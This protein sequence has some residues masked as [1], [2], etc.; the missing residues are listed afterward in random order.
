V[1]HISCYD[2]A[3]N[4]EKTISDFLSHLDTIIVNN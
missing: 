4:E 2:I 3:Q 1:Y